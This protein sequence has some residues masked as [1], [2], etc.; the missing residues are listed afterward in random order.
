MRNIQVMMFISCIT[1]GLFL[2]LHGPAFF[3][4]DRYDPTHGWQFDATSARLL[5]GGL[6]ALA[7]VGFIFLRH[8]YGIE[9]RL[10]GPAMQWLYFALVVLALGLISLAINLA[11]PV[12]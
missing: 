2:L 4:P 9:R 5:G 10:P 1:L 3:L 11:D 12:G 7:A 6:L 8:H